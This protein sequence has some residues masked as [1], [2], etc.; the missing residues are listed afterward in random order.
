MMPIGYLM[1]MRC[2]PQVDMF[3][4]LEVLMFLGDHETNH[5]DKIY[6]ENKTHSTRHNYS[7]GRLA[8]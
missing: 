6:Y 8:S 2:V 3:S 5:N 4:L 1:L 7:G